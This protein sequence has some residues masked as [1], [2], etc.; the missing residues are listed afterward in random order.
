MIGDNRYYNHYFCY[1]LRWSDAGLEM[2]PL[3]VVMWPECSFLLP[4]C[5]S[6]LLHECPRRPDVGYWKLEAE[7][8]LWKLEAEAG[9]WKLEAEAGLWKLEAE[10]G[11]WKLAQSFGFCLLLILSAV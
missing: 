8:G 7:A 9:L 10:A 1:A 6:E 3:L 4:P 5:W 11:L 2:C